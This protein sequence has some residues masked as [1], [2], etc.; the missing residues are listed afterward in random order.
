MLLFS[1]RSRGTVVNVPS[2]TGATQN[3]VA[4][5]VATLR[6]TLG[7]T[8]EQVAGRSEGRLKRTEIVKIEGGGN[9]ATSDKV[10][11]GLAVAFG[12]TRDLVA[13][14]LDGRIELPELLRRKN[15]PEPPRRL[16]VEYDDR[17]QHR[18]EA[19]RFAEID[20][21]DPRAVAFIRSI[22][23]HSDEDPPAQWWLDQIRAHEARLKFAEKDPL[24]AEREREA[25]RARVEQAKAEDER[26]KA[27]AKARRLAKQRGEG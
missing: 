22:Q 17:Y 24:G 13:D 23:H 9:K 21:V 25:S 19:I 6:D 10:R 15:E 7:L 26:A 16:V 14:Y 27:E 1:G 3:T 2:D 4:A 18:V 11:A 12:L 8:Q 5:R 20:G